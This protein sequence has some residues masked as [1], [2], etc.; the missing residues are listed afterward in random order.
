MTRTSP[1]PE[2]RRPGDGPRP[3]GPLLELP[4]LLDESTAGDFV[5]SDREFELFR[6]LVHERTGISLGPH[7]RHLLRARL[8]RRLRALGLATFAAYYEYLTDAAGGGD[9]MVSFINAITTNKTD[10]FREAHHFEYLGGRWAQARRS[11]GDRTGRRR[12][13]LWSAASSSGEEVYT[14]AMVLAEAKLVPP[15]WDTRLLASDIDTDMLAQTSAA[16]YPMDRIGPVPPELLK[17]YFLRRADRLSDEVR[18]RQELRAL[19]TVRRINLAEA[20]WPI[21]T[22]FDVIFCRNALIYFD[23]AMQKSILEHLLGYLEPGGLL[24][25]GHAESVYGLVEDLAHLGN[26]IYARSADVRQGRLP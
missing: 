3:A 23:R 26:T 22:R 20:Q 21:R 24:F 8:G 2:P 1:P 12:L 18:I 4:A 19:V 10:F 17:R 5:I 25:L 9:E 14:L 11:D 6:A 16:I 13:R 15:A 7:K